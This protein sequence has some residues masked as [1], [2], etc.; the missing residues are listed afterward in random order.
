[1][2]ELRK[3]PAQNLQELFFRAGYRS[4]ATASRNFRLIAGCSP[5][6]FIEKNRGECKEDNRR[7]TSTASREQL[8]E[9]IKTQL[10]REPSTCPRHNF[11]I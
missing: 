9:T 5:S 1:M 7:E 8:G 3:A 6:E 11:I 4:R 2:S 10:W